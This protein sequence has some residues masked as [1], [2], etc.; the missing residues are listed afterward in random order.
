MTA[1]TL[2]AGGIELVDGIHR[3]AAATEIGIDMVPVR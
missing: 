3:W 2:L 1:S